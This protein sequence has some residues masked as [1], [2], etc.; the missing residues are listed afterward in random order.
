VFLVGF[1]R[2]EGLQCQAGIA[3]VV[4]EI[5]PGAS[6]VA[7]DDVENVDCASVHWLRK[8]TN[9]VDETG[10]M[11]VGL[12]PCEWVVVSASYGCTTCTEADECLLEERSSAAWQ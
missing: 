8:W 4:E 12:A 1:D 7:I 5:L 11:C 6:G 10:E 3:L 9:R 2:E